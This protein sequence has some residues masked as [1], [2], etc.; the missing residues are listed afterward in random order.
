MGLQDIKDMTCNVTD[1]SELIGIKKSRV[2]RMLARMKKGKGKYAVKVNF[3][4]SI[5]YI[6]GYLKEYGEI[7]VR[8][9]KMPL[10]DSKKY[11]E[12]FKEW[13][14]L[15]EKEVRDGVSKEAKTEEDNRKS[16]LIGGKNYIDRELVTGS[17]NLDKDLDDVEDMKRDDDFPYQLDVSNGSGV[18]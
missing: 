14:E 4:D 10:L 9:H 13:K 5:R 18:K 16:H 8:D 7:G 2:V 15:A 1:L 6:I 17:D 3:L 11:E 12:E